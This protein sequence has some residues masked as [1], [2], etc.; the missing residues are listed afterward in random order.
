MEGGGNNNNK[1]FKNN[2]YW[3]LREPAKKKKKRPVVSSVHTCDQK[4][5]HQELERLNSK[6]ECL[7]HDIWENQT[8][9]VWIPGLLAP[10]HSPTF[11]ADCP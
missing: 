8:H 1:T 2:E 7:K 3:K 10:S 11:L 4:L 5:S 6:T 9:V